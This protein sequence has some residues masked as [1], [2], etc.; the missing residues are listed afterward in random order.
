MKPLFVPSI[1]LLASLLLVGTQDVVA[2][3]RG[4]F[5]SLQQG[6]QGG[7]GAGSRSQFGTTSQS[8]RQGQ[9]GQRQQ[10]SSGFGQ[11]RNQGRQGSNFSQQSRG[12]QDN[13]IGNDA[14]QIRNQQNNRNRGQARRAMFN[15]AIESLNELRKSRTQ[16]H[17]S[18]SQKPQVRV[19]LRPLFSVEQPSAGELTTHVR[20]QLDKTL[21]STIAATQI[22]VSNGTAT[23]AGSVKSEYDKQLAAKMLSLQPGILQVEN[24]LTIES[25]LPEPLLFPSQ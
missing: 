12:Q 21:P 5:G 13:F 22:S 25:N 1:L 7:F 14:Q 18:G 10:R 11:S 20:T 9:A 17:S 16:Q 6:Q 2:Q 23:I 3:S 8:S 15:F 24:R 4:S 19:Q